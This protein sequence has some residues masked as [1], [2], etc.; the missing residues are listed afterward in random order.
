[1]NRFD[2]QMT[3]ARNIV[4]AFVVG[5]CTYGIVY[6][7]TNWTDEPPQVFEVIPALAG[8]GGA[9]LAYRIMKGK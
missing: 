2:K 7:M 5:A 1:M 8:I 3:I 9:Y 4:A 6:V